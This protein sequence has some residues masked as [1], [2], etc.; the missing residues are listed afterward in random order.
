MKFTYAKTFSDPVLAALTKKQKQLDINKDGKIDSTDLKR[1]RKGEKP[2]RA[3]LANFK[4]DFLRSL[5]QD[6]PSVAYSTLSSDE[7]REEFYNFKALGQ[8]EYC[9]SNMQAEPRFLRNTKARY[10]AE[11]ASFFKLLESKQIE[12]LQPYFKRLS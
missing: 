7:E 1:L 8:L 4:E 12:L 5:A 3:A 11:V 6:L 9:V 2:V 10:P